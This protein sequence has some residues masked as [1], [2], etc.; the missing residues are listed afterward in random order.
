MKKFSVKVVAQMTGWAHIAA[1]S[2]SEA[3]QKAKEIY[4][5]RGIDWYEE[6]L[7]SCE[8][9][10]VDTLKDRLSDIVGV[11]RGVLFAEPR[12]E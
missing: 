11:D 12:Q 8:I 7:V 10:D 5:K 9:D 6:N 4:E 3:V 2:E 1:E